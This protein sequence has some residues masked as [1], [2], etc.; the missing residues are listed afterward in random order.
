MWSPGRGVKQG[1]KFLGTCSIDLIMERVAFI[2]ND[3]SHTGWTRGERESEYNRGLIVL[4]FLKYILQADTIF[5][6]NYYRE[7]IN[8]MECDFTY[9]LLHFNSG[10]KHL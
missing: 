7:A 3:G 6:S 4:Y 8:S 2:R 1:T 5:E 9:C 10:F